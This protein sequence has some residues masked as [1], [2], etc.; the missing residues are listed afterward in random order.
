MPT[1][2]SVLRN[3]IHQPDD[4]APRLAYADLVEKRARTVAAFGR[5]VKDSPLPVPLYFSC[6]HAAFRMWDPD[7]HDA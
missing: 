7:R 2:E 3:I 6:F 1:L 5:C 4:D